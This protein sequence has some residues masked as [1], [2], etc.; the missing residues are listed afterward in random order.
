MVRQC[1]AVEPQAVD[2]QVFPQLCPLHLINALAEYRPHRGPDGLRTVEVRT[3]PGQDD[4]VEA[5]RIGRAEDRP[6]VAGVLDRFEDQCLSRRRG[7]PVGKFHR[8]HHAGGTFQ[9]GSIVQKLR[10]YTVLRSSGNL[11]RGLVR[12]EHCGDLR[13]VAQCLIQQLCTVADELARFPPRRTFRA[14]PAEAADLFVFPACQSLHIPAH[15][16]PIINLE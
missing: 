6:E 12:P 5:Q 3:V 16:I 9:R 11:R 4:G 14:Q 8:E 10:R 2:S 15:T 1:R 13:T 7:V